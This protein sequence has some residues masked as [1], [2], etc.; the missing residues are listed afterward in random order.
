[1]D[2]QLVCSEIIA[3]SG[4]EFDASGEGRLAKYVLV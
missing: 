1:M 4:I 2:S 3:K